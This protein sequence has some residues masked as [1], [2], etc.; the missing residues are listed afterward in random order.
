MAAA[1]DGDDDIAYDFILTDDHAPI[2]DQKFPVFGNQVLCA[3]TSFE[4]CFISCQGLVGCGGDHCPV[5][6][7]CNSWQEENSGLMLM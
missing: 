5:C 1:E 6:Q 2:S 7:C 4:Y 3:S